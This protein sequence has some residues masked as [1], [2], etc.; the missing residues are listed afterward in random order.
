[1]WLRVKSHRGIFKETVKI[2]SEGPRVRK[3]HPL[4]APVPEHPV[5]MFCLRIS[6]SCQSA[7]TTTILLLGR[8]VTW[9][10]S[11]RVHT[12]SLPRCGADHQVRDHR[13]ARVIVRS[14]VMTRRSTGL[15]SPGQDAGPGCH[16]ISDDLNMQ[17]VP[18]PQDGTQTRGCLSFL[19]PA[20]KIKSHNHLPQFCIT[21]HPKPTTGLRTNYMTFEPAKITL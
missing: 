15:A 12:S 9:P 18:K 21:K 16:R 10:S 14:C 4:F 17:P 2:D 11:A 8:D 7:Y 20:S 3:R 6:G 5:L 19:F 1:M 13:L